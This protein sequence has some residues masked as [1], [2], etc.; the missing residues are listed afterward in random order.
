MD[1]TNGSW[2]IFAVL[3]FHLA[4][5]QP[6][7]GFQRRSV[8]SLHMMDGC[9]YPALSRHFKKTSVGKFELSGRLRRKSV[10]KNK[11]TFLF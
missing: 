10:K 7:N 1:V 8:H 6:G 9:K 4:T 3:V 11:K 5:N 2:H